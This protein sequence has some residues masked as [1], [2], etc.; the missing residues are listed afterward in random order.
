MFIIPQIFFAV[1]TDLKIGEYLTIR[2]GYG[3]IA[4]EAKP[5]GPLRAKKGNNKVRRCKLKKSLFGEKNERKTGQFRYSM[6]IA[7]SPPVA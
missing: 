4:H 2:P 1:C 7:S 5:N 6:T 3:S